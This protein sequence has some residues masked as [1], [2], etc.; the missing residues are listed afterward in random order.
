MGVSCQGGIIIT[1]WKGV[2]VRVQRALLARSGN[3]CAFPGCTQP[4]VN[5]DHELV[6]SLCH[7]EAVSPG[8]PRH[9][10]DQTDDERNSYSNLMYLCERH[11]RETHDCSKYSVETL[12]EMKRQHES[13]HI[14]KPWTID[15]SLLSKLKIESD[16]YAE[17][18][19]RVND[20]CN[21]L[22][23]DIKMEINS[24][25]TALELI[26]HLREVLAGLEALQDW[27]RESD[28]RAYDE[29]KEFIVRLGYD[30]DKVDDIPYYENPFQIRNWDIHFLGIPN[31]QTMISMFLLQ[32]EWRCL[33]YEV[34]L[35]PGD[36]DFRH[37]LDRVK[38]ELKGFALSIGYID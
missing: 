22:P 18:L 32:L 10:P 30:A 14:E 20:V 28:S 21:T 25:L 23:D 26:E 27:L 34:A 19:R 5:E 6:A 31:H 1:A 4:I 24:H 17:E 9:N 37:E 2:S 35:N 8:G 38:E 13:E 29:L 11:H 15:W 3:E 7:I 16:A 12:K 36:P 33:E